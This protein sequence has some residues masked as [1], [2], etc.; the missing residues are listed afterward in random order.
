MAQKTKIIA[1]A[2]IALSLAACSGGD[3]PPAEG[4][5]TPVTV[6]VIPI[7]DTAA[8]W[9]GDQEG[10][11][12]EEGIDLTIE[13]TDGGATSMAGVVSGDYDFAFSNLVS[14][15]VAQ[16]QGLPVRYVTNGTSVEGTDEGFGAVV[17]PEDSDIERPADLVG[18]TVSVNN[19]SNIT[20]AT[21]SYAVEQDGGD[22][23]GIDYVELPF[24]DMPAALAAG[25]I[26]AAMIVEPFLTAVRD[27]GARVVA[28]N[29]QAIP[30]MDIAGYFA[31][32]ETIESD[33]EL[34]ERFARAMNR[35]LERAG[36]DPDAVREVVGTYTEISADARA[37]MNLP[38]FRT[39]FNVEA[40]EE[41]GEAL[42]RYGIVENAPD[43]AAIL[44][45]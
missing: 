25:N 41:L 18:R 44:P 43:V 1:T 39:E 10:Y 29:Y 12:E 42:V 32:T 3:Q 30:D 19:L 6:G 27:E 17:V 31:T 20:G 45:Q 4:D 28:W 9:L 8:L 15:M 34:V 21:A 14:L 13:T 37:R 5:L 11:F 16:D 2:A 23:N 26:D 35:S 40:A 36:E 38:V 22:P 7:T 24:P 33:P